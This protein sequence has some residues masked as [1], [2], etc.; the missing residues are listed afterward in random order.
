MNNI[1]FNFSK[2][3]LFILHVVF[4][5]DS[6][7]SFSVKCSLEM[8]HGSKEFTSSNICHASNQQKTE[9]NLWE[10]A[11]HL[12]M[13]W[14]LYFQFHTGT[15]C[16][17]LKEVFVKYCAS[18]TKISWSQRGLSQKWFSASASVPRPW[19][20]LLRRSLRASRMVHT[21]DVT[22]TGEFE[23][24]TAISN[25]EQ[26]GFSPCRNF[27]GQFISQIGVT[28]YFGVYNNPFF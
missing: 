6:N 11:L 20:T 12:E 1:P 4:K 24:R 9:N 19:Y 17:R 3:L 16:R 14:I 15:T 25:F 7:V 28:A 22:P 2:S 10:R 27:L 21:P 5:G 23:V 8:R 26:V 18:I 13:I